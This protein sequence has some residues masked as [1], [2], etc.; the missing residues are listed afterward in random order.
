MILVRKEVAKDI[1]GKLA[2]TT[3][4]NCQ[5]K[6]KPIRKP[7]NVPEK[8]IKNVGTFSPIAFYIEEVSV[9]TFVAN[10]FGFILSYQA[11]S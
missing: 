10:S 2:D 1:A 11:I 9:A 4:A 7:K 6:M 8:A 3:N 5:P